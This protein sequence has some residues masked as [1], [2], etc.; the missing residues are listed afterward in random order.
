MNT[1]SSSVASRPD[2]RPGAAA[3]VVLLLIEGYRLALS[4]LLG[5]FCRFE[6]SC[7]RYATEAVTRHG[8]WRGCGLAARRIL[9]CHPFRPGGFDPVP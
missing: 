5:G 9:R 1:S 8:A 6:P 7:S 4:P 3:R 2:G